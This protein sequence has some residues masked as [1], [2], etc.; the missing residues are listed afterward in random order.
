MA[1]PTLEYRIWQRGVEWHWQV[2]Q[3]MTG[4]QQFM[5]T[6]IADSSPAARSAAFR[7]CLQ[8]QGNDYASLFFP[9]TRLW[10]H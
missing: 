10:S 5:A 4:Y 2:I 6:G 8:Y 9:S 7:Y 3:V 1:E